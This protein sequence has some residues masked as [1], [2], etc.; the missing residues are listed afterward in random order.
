M[1]PQP[2]FDP[3]PQGVPQPQFQPQQQF[4]PLKYA[5]DPPQQPVYAVAPQPVPLAP[6]KKEITKLE[7]LF[8][9]FPIK[10]SLLSSPSL[11]LLHLTIHPLHT[12][13]FTYPA[14][15]ADPDL[16]VV[17]GKPRPAILVA[18]ISFLIC[19]VG[20][21]IIG[22][23]KKGVIILI[24]NLIQVVLISAFASILAYFTFGIGYI[25][26]LLVYVFYLLAI[27]DSYMVAQRQEQG[28]VIH[29]G[30]CYSRFVSFL[31]FCF[32]LFASFSLS[33]FSP[34]TVI[35]S[36]SFLNAGSLF[37]SSVLSW[38]VLLL[39]AAPILHP[40]SNPGKLPML[41]D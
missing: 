41:R 11:F 39:S 28:W 18:L 24:I 4:Y 12:N 27:Y 37:L 6:S 40:L 9:N 26:I 17:N 35:Y 22:Q 31:L 30:E 21:M 7:L 20:H 38:E 34:D 36:F 14:V 8:W 13:I 10:I 25:L 33:F 29:K 1:D 16:I 23:V 32:A 3:Q 2:Q 19:G 5:S 15:S